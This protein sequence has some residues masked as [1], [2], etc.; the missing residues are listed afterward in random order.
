MKITRISLL[1]AVVG[2]AGLTASAG[3]LTTKTSIRG[4]SGVVTVVKVEPARTTI[5]LSKQ[6]Q[7]VGDAR[8][9]SAPR[10]YQWR[11]ASRPVA[12]S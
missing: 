3:D 10:K 12:G 2:V 6:D 7:G 5:A 8:Q 1:A 11:N 9:E 4:R